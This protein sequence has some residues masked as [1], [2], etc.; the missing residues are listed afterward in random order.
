[1]S[2]MDHS[3][4][5]TT[6]RRVLGLPMMVFY[7]VG[8]TIG[9]GI[10]ALIGEITRIAGDHAPMAFLLAGVIAGATGISYAKLASVY[11]RAAG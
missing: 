11:P 7:G 5:K 8:V 9:A 6:L 2:T 1:M 4:Q 3:N 10:F